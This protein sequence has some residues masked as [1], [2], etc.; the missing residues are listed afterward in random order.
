[1]SALLA[2]EAWVARIASRPQTTLMWVD[3]KDRSFKLY[4]PR[5]TFP[6][7]GWVEIGDF[8]PAWAA[9]PVGGELESRAP[10]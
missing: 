2:K 4:P 6:D 7:N 5:S 3:E 10:S 9:K 1:M 8:A